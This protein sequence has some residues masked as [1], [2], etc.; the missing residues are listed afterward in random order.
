MLV[1]TNSF[2]ETV[3]KLRQENSAYAK[4]AEFIDKAVAA[5]SDM[6]AQLEPLATW[7]ETPDPVVEEQLLAQEI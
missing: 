7:E 3:D 6:I 1:P 2:A 5:N 4:Q